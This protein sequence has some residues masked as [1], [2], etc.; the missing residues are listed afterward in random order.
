MSVAKK[1]KSIAAVNHAAKAVITV[2]ALVCIAASCI[3]TELSRAAAEQNEA[4]F[5]HRRRLERIVMRSHN[6]FTTNVTCATPTDCRPSFSRN[7]KSI[8]ELP[9]RRQTKG[10][11]LAWTSAAI[12][13]GCSGDDTPRIKRLRTERKACD[14]EAA[15]AAHCGPA[16]GSATTPP[17][18]S[19]NH[20]ADTAIF[21]F[22]PHNASL[23]PRAKALRLCESGTRSVRTRSGC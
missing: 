12:S 15:N 14:D 22:F 8:T 4:R 16:K 3:T 23:E 6:Y 1:W 17:S 10:A 2:A 5:D 11:G 19:D 18:L 9:A 13:T 7:A 21:I 20:I